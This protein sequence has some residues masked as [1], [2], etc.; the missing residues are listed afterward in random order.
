MKKFMFLLAS[1]FVWNLSVWA[2]SDKPIAMEKMPSKAQQFIKQYF[3]GSAV[4][5]SKMDSDFINRSYDVIFTNGDKVEF[6]RKGDWTDVDCQY[7]QVPLDVIPAPIHTYVSKAY[8][9]VTYKKIEKDRKGYEVKLSNGWEW[10][11]NRSF[12][13]VDLDD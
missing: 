8:P 2:G 1:L 12:Q 5:V 7:S 13:V 11:F 3:A 10:K 9:N 6:D 4:A